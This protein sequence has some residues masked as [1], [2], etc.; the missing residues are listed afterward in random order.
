LKIIVSAYKALQLRTGGWSN[1]P[2]AAFYVPK[3]RRRNYAHAAIWGGP[4]ETVLSMCRELAARVEIDLAAGEFGA[5]MDEE[6]INW[7]ASFREFKWFPKNIE[8]YARFAATPRN[9]SIFLS[10]DKNSMDL[11]PHSGK[12]FLK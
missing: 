2:N 6:Y 8:G 5:W 9:R 4:T 1:C 12:R 3:N 11:H 10:L 7:W